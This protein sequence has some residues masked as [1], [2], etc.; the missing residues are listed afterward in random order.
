MN[1]P[2][3]ISSTGLYTPPHVITNEEIVASFNA[4]VDIFNREHQSQI[5]KGEVKALEY[6]SASFIEKASGIKQ[7]YVLDKKGILDP[8]RMRP[9]F[10]KRSDDAPSLQCEFALNAI[11]A[12][13]D[14][15]QKTP[16]EVDGLIVSCTNHQ[17]SYPGISI[18][19]QKA[20]G[21][22]GYA[23]D[24]HVACSS[25]TF[26]LANAY[27]AIRS[28]QNKCIVLVTPEITTA[29]LNFRDRDS[30]FI[31]GDICT[32]I[33]LERAD[34]CKR[35]A[36]EITSTKLATD[37]S[38]NIRNNDGFMCHTELG[39]NDLIPIQY[40]SQN[41][42]KVFKEVVPMV[43]EHILAHLAEQQIPVSAIK[44]FWLHQA[45][46]NM[47]QLI[48]TKILGREPLFLDAPIVLDK[49]ANGASCGSIIAFHLYNDD[50]KSG[51]QGVICSFG[52]GYSIG[53]VTVRKV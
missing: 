23:Y 50:F 1:H 46:I 32:A 30:H 42:R 18:E 44:R 10:P 14:H 12:A 34:T 33:V 8:Q 22:R 15:A 2:V 35:S 29:H 51:E 48:A 31:F 5:E 37:F 40:F 21:M 6:S 19:V 4:Y 47:N 3:V 13:L 16:Q 9:Y 39:N 41:G 26:G 53:S 25:T 7:R 52:A 28:G 20:M 17:R 27:N 36:F 49:Y 43:E 38:N 11:H 24:M 45:N